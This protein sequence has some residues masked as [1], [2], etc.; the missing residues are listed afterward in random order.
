MLLKQHLL[1]LM[2]LWSSSYIFL[3]FTI[4]INILLH[5]EKKQSQYTQN[6]IVHLCAL[7]QYLKINDLGNKG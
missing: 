4:T 3:H 6:Q 1:C 5:Y 7:N 2:F